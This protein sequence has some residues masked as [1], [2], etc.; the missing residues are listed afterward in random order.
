MRDSLGNRIK[1]QYEN[2]TRYFLPRRTYTIIRCDGKA[3][4]SFTRGCDKPFDH[5]LMTAMDQTT[6]AL[7]EEIQGAKFGFTQSDE[8]S[9]LLTDFESIQ[10]CAWFDG[11][12]QKMASIAS[13]IA[14]AAFN[15]IYKEKKNMALFDARVFT[16]PDPVEVHNYFVWR[17]QD[18]SRNSVQMAARAVF[19][20]KECD[21]KNVSELQEML[22]QKGINWDKY[23]SGEKRGRAIIKEQ[24]M[25]K[26]ETGEAVQR[27]HWMAY[28]GEEGRNE[29]P[30]FTQDKDFLE[31]RI[32]KLVKETVVCHK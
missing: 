20:H 18:A 11:N 16:I 9:I 6:I 32:P 28:T 17:Q 19:S 1:E 23:T 7:C 22:F 29:T 27:S 5:K 30:I 13:S 25:L 8:I 3:F 10:T 14:T 12:I 21:N 26:T 4:H 24:Y 2:R 31:K 15:D